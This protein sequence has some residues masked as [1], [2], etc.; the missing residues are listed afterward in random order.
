MAQLYLEETV[1]EQ[2]LRYPIYFFMKNLF[3]AS[4]TSKVS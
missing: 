2:K 1:L 3:S 4:A